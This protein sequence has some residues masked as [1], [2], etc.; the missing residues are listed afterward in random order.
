MN[1][2]TLGRGE[3]T[4][5]GGG[6]GWGMGGGWAQGLPYL[7]EKSGHPRVQTDKEWERG[8]GGGEG[9]G[10]TLCHNTLSSS[11]CICI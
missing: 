9:L 10:P 5:R 1:L 8:G 7:P 4:G 6:W 2:G 11:S 3:A